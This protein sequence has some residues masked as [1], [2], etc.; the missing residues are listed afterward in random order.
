VVHATDRY[1]PSALPV[2][3][4]YEL[5]SEE[6]R[7]L[8]SRPPAAALE[9]AAAAFGPNAR[10]LHARSRPGGTSSAIHVVT[11]DDGHGERHHAVLRR[12]VRPDVMH[13]ASAEVA[14]EAAA[15]RLLAAS[16]LPTPR[17]IAADHSGEAAGVPAVLM[18]LLPGRIEWAPSPARLEPFL[19]RLAGPLLAIGEVTV[20][21]NAPIPAYRPYE[22]GRTLGPPPWS[23]LPRRVWDT[24]VALYQGAPPLPDRRFIH[25]DY[26]PGN[27]LW[28]RG[29][30]SGVVDWQH[31]SLG[32]LEADVGHCR[33]NL[34]GHFS[35]AVADRFLRI[36]QAISGRTDYHPYWDVA[37]VLTAPGSYGPPD[38]TLD[39]FVAAAIAR[40]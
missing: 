14:I 9:W 16:S 3:H 15:L 30:V 7:L 10:V 37:V 5:A 27:V 36:W 32:A 12:Y 26:H 21:T 8:R 1:D 24:A 29:A 19:E 40:L 31:A 25:R 28:R 23:R 39:E 2:P 33:A 22:L 4:G 35:A 18:S 38:A 17:L 6:R 11:V 13:E 20:P 34:H